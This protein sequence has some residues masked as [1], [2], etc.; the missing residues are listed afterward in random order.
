MRKFFWVVPLALA[1]IVSACSSSND[2]KMDP[3]MDHSKMNM[4]NTGSGQT[5]NQGTNSSGN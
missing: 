1:L 4:G 5:N 3:N 2:E